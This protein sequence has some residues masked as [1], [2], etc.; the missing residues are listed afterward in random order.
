MDLAVILKTLQRMGQFYKIVKGTK[1]VSVFGF[2]FRI[3]V[4]GGDFSFPALLQLMLT[5]PKK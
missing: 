4:D 3:S 5:L 2:L 1:N